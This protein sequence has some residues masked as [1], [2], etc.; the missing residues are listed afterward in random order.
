MGFDPILSEKGTIAYSPDRPLDES[1]Y[2]EAGDA[3]I[4]VLIIGGR[5]GSKQSHEADKR[6]AEFFDRYD[7]ITKGEYAA[8]EASNTAIYVLIEETVFAEYRTFQ[9]NR[10][11]TDIK[12]A[13]VDSANVFRLIEEIL[14]RR[15]NN[16]VF[17]FKSS[18]EIEGW[19]REQ[20]AGLFRELLGNSRTQRQL[21]TLNTSVDALAETSRTLQRYLETV[22]EK[23]APQNANKLIS[24]ELERLG[25]LERAQKIAANPFIEFMAKSLEIPLG[26][27]ISAVNRAKNQDELVQI[28]GEITGQRS[29]MGLLRG[30]FE[31][32]DSP[33]DLRRLRLDMGLEPFK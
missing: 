21:T 19:L 31:L 23:I 15:R 32:V 11:R 33:I 17:T 9:R 25:E 5:Y 18:D 28:V 2:R 7:S 26:A 6:P 12:Y 4:L 13:H 3:D 27:A 16:P 24:K 8:A 29:A 30:Y 10:E 20:W 1:C 22:M 14:D